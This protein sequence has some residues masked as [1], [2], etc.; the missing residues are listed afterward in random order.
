VILDDASIAESIIWQSVNIGS[1]V[2][3]KSSII[4]NDCRLDDG[5]IVEEA[6]LGDNVT[7]AS[8][9]NLEPGSKI[10]PGTAVR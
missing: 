8:G 7:V 3:V 6:V 1:G 9:F 10:W 4:A 5:S 2:K